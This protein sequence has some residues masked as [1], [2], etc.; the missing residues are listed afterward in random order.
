M[1]PAK[2]QLSHKETAIRPLYLDKETALIKDSVNSV[3]MPEKGQMLGNQLLV[4]AKGQVLISQF[5]VIN[6][7]VINTNVAP[8][9]VMER[10]KKY[11]KK[12]R[13]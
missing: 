9:K 2:G 7:H 8:T 13:N 6:T 11:E 10:P 5:Y 3:I 1:L 12:I 4:P